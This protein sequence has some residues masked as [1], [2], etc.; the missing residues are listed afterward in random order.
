MQLY[1]LDTDI[2]GFVQSEHPLVLEHIKSL[3]IDA[4]VVTTVITFG[5]DLSG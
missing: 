2:I 4:S 3:P 1:V 5:E